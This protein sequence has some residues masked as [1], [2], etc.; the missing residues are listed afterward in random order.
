MR[1]SSV[2]RPPHA[3]VSIWIFACGN[4]FF[5][6]SRNLSCHRV[7]GKSGRNVPA[8]TLS[9]HARIRRV[10]PFLS[11][12]QVFGSSVAAVP[13]VG[14]SSSGKAFSRTGKNCSS[15]SLSSP[16]LIQRFP[17]S[18]SSCSSVGGSGV[19]ECGFPCFRVM[20]PSASRMTESIRWSVYA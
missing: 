13:S 14:F 20:F 16:A 12:S 1:K 18:V 19:A 7:A 10:S 15:V 17:R 11:F 4:C 9:P 3:T 2:F 6:A 8:V 5:S